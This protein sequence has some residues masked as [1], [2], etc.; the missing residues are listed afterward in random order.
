MNKKTKVAIGVAVVLL[1]L[2][3]SVS[4]IGDF[5][6]PIKFVSEVTA[7]PENYLNRNVQVAG[8][9]VQES[10]QKRSEPNSYVFELTDGHATIKVEYSGSVPVPKVKPGVGVTVIGVLTSE[11]TLKSNKILLKCPSKYQEELTKAYYREQNLSYAG[12]AY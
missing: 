11:D 2:W 12:G 10:L 6:N 8:L 3:M 1:G 7:Q 5:L 4:A 9:I